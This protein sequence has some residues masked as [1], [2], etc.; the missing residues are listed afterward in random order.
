M[1]ALQGG[2]AQHTQHTWQ[3]AP[4][5]KCS[6]VYYPACTLCLSYPPVNCCASN[7]APKRC[8]FLQLLS[9]LGS[10]SM[11]PSAYTDNVLGPIIQDTRVMLLLFAVAPTHP[12]KSF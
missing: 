7:I 5:T 6:H 2:S 11:P 8:V 3:L 4:E 10:A 9:T 12:L 1:Y